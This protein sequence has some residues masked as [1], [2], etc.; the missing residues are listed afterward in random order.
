MNSAPDVVGHGLLSRFHDGCRC[1]WCTSVDRERTCSCQD[2]V[3]LRTTSPYIELLK[4]LPGEPPDSD[5]GA[6]EVQARPR[7]ERLLARRHD[8]GSPWPRLYPA[9]GAKQV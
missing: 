6:P 7:G 1:P 5:Q 8:G 4:A 3:G 2:C 9:L